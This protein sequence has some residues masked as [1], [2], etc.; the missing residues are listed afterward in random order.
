MNG[1]KEQKG[2]QSHGKDIDREILLSIDNDKQLLEKCRLNK[3]FFNEVCDDTFFKNR[4]IQKHPN[5]LKYKEFFKNLS[6]KQYFLQVVYY[7]A[8]LKEDYEHDYTDGNFKKQ[9]ELFQESRNNMD[10]FL[11]KSSFYGEL[12]LVKE[13]LKRRAYIHKNNDLA[14]RR[15]SQH[16]HLEVVKYLVEHGAD[17]HANDDEALQLANLHG[18]TE[19]VNYLKSL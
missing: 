7:I 9:L 12:S 13:A 18:K 15:A 17:I 19:V 5:T 11:Y 14:L 16:G 2:F 8:K 1:Q 3:Y 6:W 10:Y 4:L